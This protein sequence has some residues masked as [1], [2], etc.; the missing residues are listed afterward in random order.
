MGSLLTFGYLDVPK[1]A[2]NVETWR[3]WR[4]VFPIK[5]GERKPISIETFL[6]NLEKNWADSSAC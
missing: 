1:A 5:T 4:N 2:A 6:Q 3:T